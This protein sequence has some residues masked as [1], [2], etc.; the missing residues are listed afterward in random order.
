MSHFT[1]EDIV[2]VGDRSLRREQSRS[3]RRN[4]EFEGEVLRQG[5]LCVVQHNVFEAG[6]LAWNRASSKKR[7][8]GVDEIDG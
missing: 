6:R 8:G 3:Y 4:R 1:V 7:A 2:A 5:L